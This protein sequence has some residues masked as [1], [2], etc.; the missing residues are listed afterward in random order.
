MTTKDNSMRLQISGSSTKE[1]IEEM[2]KEIYMK[3]IMGG[4]NLGTI[5]VSARAKM[6]EGTRDIAFEAA[7]IFY[8]AEQ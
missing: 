4:Q 3:S 2:A 7:R 5:S 1:K 8:G 6:F